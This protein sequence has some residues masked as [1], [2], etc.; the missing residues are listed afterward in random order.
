MKRII[1]LIILFFA[2]IA[3]SPMLI[4]EKGYILIALGNLTIESTV[5][6]AT[7][8]L[9]TLFIILLIIIR[10]IRGG[11]NL[12]LGAWNKFAFA[13]QR[14]ALRNLKKGIAA[15]ILGDH[16]QAEHLL[17]KS[18]EPSH[19]EQ[20]A[21]LLAASAANKQ[22]LTTNTKHYLAQLAH[23][24][25]N[26]KDVGLESVLVT[27][28]LLIDNEEYGQARQLIDN[29]HK[30]IG[31]DDRLLAQ[32]ITLSL[33]ENRFSYVVEQLIAARKSKTITNDTIEQWEAT[34][35]FGVF[36]EQIQ[37]QNSEA[38]NTYWNNL[39][40]KIKQREQVVFAYCRVLA[41]NQITQ[42]LSKIL[43]PVIKKGANEKLLKQMRRLPLTSS[44]EL[45]Q[46]VQKHLHHDKH[47][48]QWLSCLAHL[49]ANSQQ[50]SMAEKAFNSLVHL[51]GEQ[52][53][54]VDLITFAHVLE[55]QN[56][57]TKAIEVLN[58]LVVEHH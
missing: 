27:I 14:R 46:A 48:A 31:H 28:Q 34:A 16:Q 38:L 55:K 21:Y 10:V 36:N 19:F 32:E 3:I 43:L 37:Q 22:G 13:S 52:Y 11:F 8:M 54:R 33:I 12:S 24:Q 42:P 4:G 18:A 53:D 41:E 47:N 44:D 25:E 57:L 35:F 2:A 17:V 7:L 20:I 56:E 58:K 15:Y 5:V 39:G 26:L 51:A 6:T 30:H 29:H 45:I 23:N 50:W 1:L 49:A 40:R 9:V